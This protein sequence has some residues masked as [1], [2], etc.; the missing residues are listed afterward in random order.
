MRAEFKFQKC[1]NNAVNQNIS[2]RFKYINV[3]DS[4]DDNESKGLWFF[5]SSK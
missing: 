5:I 3:R 4:N 2:K 1:N